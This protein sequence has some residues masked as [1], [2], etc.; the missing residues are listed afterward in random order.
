[1]VGAAVLGVAAVAMLCAPRLHAADEGQ[2]QWTYE[3][4]SNWAAIPDGA[5][6][7][8]MTGV[9]VD[10]HDNVYAFQ[11]EGP[12]EIMVFDSHGKYLRT[13]GQKAFPKGH[14]VR[15]Q[16]TRGSRNARTVG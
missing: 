8:T 7:D 5:W 12:A 4:V 2:G 15:V 13:W 16:S 1:M 11:R 6:W 9:D 10:A 14:A 3:L